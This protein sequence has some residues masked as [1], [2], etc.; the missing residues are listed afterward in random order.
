MNKHRYPPTRVGP[1]PS[2]NGRPRPRPPST[3]A[4]SPGPAVTTARARGGPAAMPI[5]GPIR[6]ALLIAAA[7]AAAAPA[8]RRRPAGREPGGDRVLRDA[9]PPDPRRGVPVVPRGDEAE[10]GAAARLAGGD[11]R[12][13][14]PRR[15]LGLPRRPGR[16]PADPGGQARGDRLDAARRAARRRGGRRPRALGRHGDAL[17]RRPDDPD[18]RAGR[19]RRRGPLGLPAGR[20]P[21]APGRQRR[22]TGSPRRSTPSSW[23]GSTRPA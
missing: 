1:A 20:R 9:G 14:L 16:Q 23:R 13:R 22:A 18:P 21:R 12:G 5:H 10:V 11:P 6:A 8:L 7:A 4:R 19:R 17:A 2:R 3:P 15:P